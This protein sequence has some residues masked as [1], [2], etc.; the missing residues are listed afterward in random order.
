MD[1]CGII[2]NMDACGIIDN[3]D[4]CETDPSVQTHSE[5]YGIVVVE[6]DMQRW[7]NRDQQPVGMVIL[8]RTYFVGH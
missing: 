1:A 5:G 2:D 8:F 4:D 3:M 7:M 6:A